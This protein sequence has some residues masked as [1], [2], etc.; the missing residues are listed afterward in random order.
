MRATG[1]LLGLAYGDA[2]GAPTEFMTVDE[3]VARY[4]PEGPRDLDGDPALIT[5]DTQMAGG[6]GGADR[7]RRRARRVRARVGLAAPTTG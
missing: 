6:V 4:G 3:I 1:C 2:L 7:A 5:D